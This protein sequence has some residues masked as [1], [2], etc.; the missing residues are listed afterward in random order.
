MP[1][2]T[3]S[4][5]EDLRRMEAQERLR[6]I[7]ALGGFGALRT[8]VVKDK[9]QYSR[10]NWKKGLEGPFAFRG[11]SSLFKLP[12]HGKDLCGGQGMGT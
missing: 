2:Q 7:E 11:A 8:Q 3:P 12:G 4:K 10:K 5:Q 1:K 6:R 9:K